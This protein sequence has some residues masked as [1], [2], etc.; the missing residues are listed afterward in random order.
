MSQHRLLLRHPR[1]RHSRSSHHGRR[2]LLQQP[3]RPPRL[4]RLQVLLLSGAHT[5]RFS[6]CEEFSRDL[7]NNTAG[8]YNLRIPRRRSGCRDAAVFFFVI[9]Q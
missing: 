7:Y 4:P 6:H 5:I 8:D 2:P 9:F 3:D 1:R